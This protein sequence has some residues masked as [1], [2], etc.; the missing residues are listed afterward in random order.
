MKGYAETYRRALDEPEAFWA[1]AADAVDWERRWDRVLDDS[2]P[3][4]YRWFAGARLN[5]CWNALDRHVAAGRGERTALIWD[6]PVT[7]T[8]QR[9][10]YRELQDRVARFAG[11]L[12]GLG[13]KPGDRVLIYLPMVPEA[14]I[15]MLACARIGAV[16]SVVFGG[17][18]AHEL[19]TRIDDA[20][21]LVV[22]TASC[23]IETSRVIPYKP[24]LDAAIAEAKSKPEACIVLQRPMCRADLVPGRDHDWQELEA[25]ARPADCVPV[26]ATDPLYILYTSG[27]TGIPKGVVRDNG[28]HAVALAWSMRHIYGVQPD[29]VF[30]TASDVG[31][32]VGHSYI[33]YG[34]LIHGCTSVMY[35]GKPVGTPDA[36]AFWRVIDE[37]DVR[38]FFTAPTA[39]RAI[40]REDPDGNL[41]RAHDLSRF[42]ALF[43]AGERADPPTVAWAEEQLRVPIID[44]W[45]QTET[46]WP[47]GANCLGVERL[48]VKHGSCTRAV[49]GWDVRV[50]EADAV[51]E[52]REMKAGEIGALAIKL[53]LP[54]GALPT[55]W[56]QDE[57]FVHSYLSAYPGYYQTAD[58][59]FIDDDGYIHVMTRTDDIINVAGHRLS[60]GGIEE[61]V[62]AH[63]DV[64]ECAVMG[65]ADPLKGQVP[66]GLVVLK[67]G[68]ERAP[69]LIEDEVVGLVRQRIGPVA[70]FKTALIVERLPKTRSG[71][72]LRATM[73]SIADGEAYRM[74]ATIDDP[75]ILPEIGEALARAGYPQRSS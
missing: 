38:V 72:I 71:K 68:V 51:G 55:L 13:V 37:H 10:T 30:W 39:F 17:F 11:V 1:E 5:T 65:V 42:R 61:V 33:V 62:A 52:A 56:Q 27:T 36:G 48:P 63:P 67:A 20:R 6:S 59:G 64:A 47:I 14:A 74:P 28:G 58:A 3:P 46:G 73:R 4:F 66:L 45:W 50:L 43:L 54:P 24:L 75:A 22:L 35:E 23:G 70:S 19:A 7:G 12:V 49:P 16:H 29:E 21:P 44:H 2:R 69:A 32:V 9:F 57:R 53:P 25:A 31:W 34:P 26:L 18:A 8:I 15:G 41:I 60:T 40:K